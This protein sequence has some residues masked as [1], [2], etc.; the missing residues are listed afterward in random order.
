M[1]EAAVDPVA[2]GAG[3]VQQNFSLLKIYLS[4]FAT[5]HESYL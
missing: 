1:G 5:Q 2:H 3:A 4:Q